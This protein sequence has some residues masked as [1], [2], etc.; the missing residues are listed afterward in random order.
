MPS[1]TDDR[2]ARFE[3]I[4]ASHH[5]DLARYARRR[6]VSRNL[7]DDVVSETFLVVWR[8]LDEVPENGCAW[9]CHRRAG[10]L[11]PAPRRPQARR[12]A[13]RLAGE[14]S[15]SLPPDADGEGDGTLLAAL[16][17][18]G[19]ADREALLLVAWEGLSRPDA[20]SALGISRAALAARLLRARARLKRQ[21]EQQ[22]EAT[23]P[24]GDPAR[25]LGGSR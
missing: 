4:F 3:R 2:R 20:A 17:R 16:A 7:A 24:A 23:D 25:R 9:P 19:E 13:E 18:L 10:A 22:D 5:G 1:A 21:M 15:E 8:R 12:L 14:W 6:A 11:R